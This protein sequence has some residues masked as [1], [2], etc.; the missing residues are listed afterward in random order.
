MTRALIGWLIRH[1]CTFCGKATLREGMHWACERS[2]L[3]PVP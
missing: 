1:S 3:G 2:L